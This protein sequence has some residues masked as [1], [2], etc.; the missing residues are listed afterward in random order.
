MADVCIRQ[1]ELRKA[2]QLLRSAAENKSL[3]ENLRQFA[4]MKLKLCLEKKKGSKQ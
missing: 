1:G 4:R 2:E 3:P